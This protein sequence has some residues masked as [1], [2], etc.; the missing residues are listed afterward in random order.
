MRAVDAASKLRLTVLV[1]RVAERDAWISE[2]EAILTVLRE[3]EAARAEEVRSSAEARVDLA[4]THLDLACSIL[5]LTWTI[6]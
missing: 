4:R 1:P 3:E 6:F 5:D 2:I